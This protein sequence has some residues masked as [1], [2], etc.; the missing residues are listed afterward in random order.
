MARIAQI[1]LRYVKKKVFIFYFICWILCNSVIHLNDPICISNITIS[2][3][4][5]EILVERVLELF[6]VED[7]C[8]VKNLAAE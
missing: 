5:L 7:L 8:V 3:L 4:N 6:Y 1:M 2:I